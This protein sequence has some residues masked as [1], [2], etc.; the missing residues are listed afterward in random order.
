[1]RLAKRRSAFTLI[2][3]LVVIAIIAILIALLV[4][5]VQKVRSAASRT[6][7]VNNL[8]QIMLAAQGYHDTY[9]V[10]PPGNDARMASA[11]MYILPYLDLNNQYA[12]F[13][14][15]TGSW[16]FSGSNN[17]PA[18][19]A[20]V[21]PAAAPNLGRWG[22]QDSPTVYTCPSA[23]PFTSTQFV[24]QMQ[25]AGTAGMNFPGGAGLAANQR[26]TYSTSPAVGT[27]G[28]TSFLPSGGY[29]PPGPAGTA[30][31]FEDYFGI[32][33]W[34][35]RVKLA[36]VTDGTSN[37]IAFLE[38]AGGQLTLGTTTGWAN[39]SWA[40]GIAYTNFWI[41]PNGGNNNCNNGPG[42]FGLAYNIPGSMHEGN[43]INVAYADGTVRNIPPSISTFS[44]LGIR[45]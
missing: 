22:A 33:T 43:R 37:T 4:P 32:F 10:L 17:V 34:K 19:A 7:C 3:L 41:C 31:Y 36:N 26:Y 28:L 30:N 13:D 40:A 1:M 14:Q 11:L 16:W 23:P 38:T 12:A 39:S 45:P 20:A 42:G 9:K 2:E 44:S 6:Q 29:M 25:T 27:V 35:S 5:A 8:K 24:L 18:T 21:A 15:T